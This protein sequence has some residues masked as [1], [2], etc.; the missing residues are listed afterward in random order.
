M[1][2]T[3]FQTTITLATADVSDLHIEQIADA[4]AA[5]GTD[6]AVAGG[7]DSLVYVIAAIK[8]ETAEDA[9]ASLTAAI[10]SFGNISATKAEPYG[11]N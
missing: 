11:E 7:T 3:E 9:I 8:A 5:A 4:A 2:A 6:V 10:T 1:T